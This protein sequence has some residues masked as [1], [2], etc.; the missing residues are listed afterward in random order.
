MDRKHIY[1]KAKHETLLER[2]REMGSRHR[3]SD[4]GAGQAS[5]SQSLA[6]VDGVFST[7]GNDREKQ[8][9]REEDELVRNGCPWKA[10]KAG[11]AQRS[12]RQMMVWQGLTTQRGWMQT[13]G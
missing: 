10:G 13:P 1:K 7:R 12:G 11:P 5:E 4:R 2:G 3:R 8:W 6:S 9:K